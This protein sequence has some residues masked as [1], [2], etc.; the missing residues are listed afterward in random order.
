MPY[1]FRCWER[2]GVLRSYAQEIASISWGGDLHFMTFSVYERRALLAEVSAS[3]LCLKIL[4]KVRKRFRARVV[5][6]VVMPDEPE[7]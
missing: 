7:T 5:G 4:E 1:P 2:V 6:Y 3:D